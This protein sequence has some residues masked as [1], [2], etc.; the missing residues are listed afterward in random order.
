MF[1]GRTNKE[2]PPRDNGRGAARLTLDRVVNWLL[3]NLEDAVA[4]GPSF[5]LRHFAETL[6]PQISHRDNQTVWNR[7]P[8]AKFVR[9]SNFRAGL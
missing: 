7:A 3:G 4:L 1:W 6:G 2:T 9:R 8:S 5:P